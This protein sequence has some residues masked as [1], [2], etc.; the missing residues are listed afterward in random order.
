MF[1]TEKLRCENRRSGSIGC[2]A[3]ASYSTNA[4]RQAAPPTID[5][6]TAGLLQPSRGCSMKP[7]TTPPSPAAQSAAPG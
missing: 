4:T 5:S 6:S 2:G 1:V 3:R 7:K